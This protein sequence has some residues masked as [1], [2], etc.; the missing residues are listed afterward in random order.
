MVNGEGN[1]K[2]ENACVR[3]HYAMK[4]QGTEKW[5]YILSRPWYYKEVCG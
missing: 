3:K 4:A 5:S 2:T 1:V